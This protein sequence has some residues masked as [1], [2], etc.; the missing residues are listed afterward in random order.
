MAAVA[1]V[2]DSPHSRRRPE[3]RTFAIHLY[4]TAPTSMSRNVDVLPSVTPFVRPLRRT[5]F[6]PN[7]DAVSQDEVVGAGCVRVPTVPCSTRSRQHGDADRKS[8][9]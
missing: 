3:R 5:R 9:A 7:A 8:A 1:A 4:R 2:P 6:H